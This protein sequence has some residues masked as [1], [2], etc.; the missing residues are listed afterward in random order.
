MS[1]KRYFKIF[2]LLV[3]SASDTMT[4]P[5]L[6]PLTAWHGK[7]ESLIANVTDPWITPTEK[8]GFRTTPDY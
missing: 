2:T 3:L 1:Y 6:P 7:S 8:S 4:Q 5:V